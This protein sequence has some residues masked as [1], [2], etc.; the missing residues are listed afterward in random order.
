MVRHWYEFINLHHTGFFFFFAK[1]ILLSTPILPSLTLWLF[2]SFLLL[3]SL[4]LIL[5]PPFPSSSPLLWS[6]IL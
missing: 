4:I 2:L 6:L 1:L 3:L 5:F